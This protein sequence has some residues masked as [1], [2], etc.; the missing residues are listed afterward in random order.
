MYAYIKGELVAV[1]NEAVVLENNGIGYRLLTAPAL[2]LRFG[3]LGAQVTAYTSLVVRE[4]VWQLFAF[5]TQ[6]ECRLFELLQTVSGIGPKVAALIL[7]GLAPDRFALAVLSG[8]VKALTAV[9]G[10]GK[11]GAERLILEL[12]DKLKH[13]AAAPPAGDF[14]APDAAA[15]AE[16]GSAMQ[17]DCL[18]ALLVLGYAPAAAKAMVEKSFDEQADLETNVR[19]AL[20]LALR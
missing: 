18:S 4:D 7:G 17:K 5:P 20:K 8:D 6:A 14:P 3:Q 15:T 10:L 19:S 12:K 13:E 2:T 1:E 16:E 11:K 9:K